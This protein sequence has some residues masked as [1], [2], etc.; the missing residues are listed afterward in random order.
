MTEEEIRAYLT[1]IWSEDETPVLP[2]QFGL[3]AVDELAADLIKQIEDTK[4][5]Q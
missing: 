2:A 4:N 3:N 5:N 1:T